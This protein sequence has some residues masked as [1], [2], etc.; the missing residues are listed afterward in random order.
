MSDGDVFGA[1][2]PAVA[3]AVVAPLSSFFMR[4][5]NNARHAGD[6]AEKN[7]VANEN[8]TT[9]TAIASP[10]QESINPPVCE[11]DASEALDKNLSGDATH[12]RCCVMCCVKCYLSPRKILI[13]SICA[14]VL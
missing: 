11:D 12:M 13:K 4:A 7:K 10:A 9:A 6:A 14:V 8:E 3:T 1:L 5:R 2:F